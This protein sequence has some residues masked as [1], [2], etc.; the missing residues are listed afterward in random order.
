MQLKLLKPWK[1]FQAG[2]VIEVDEPTANSLKAAEVACD[3][4]AADVARI[5]EQKQLVQCAVA[6]AVKGLKP[7]SVASAEERITEY[8]NFGG[9][10]RAVRSRNVQYRQRD[11][12]PCGNNETT[13]DEGGYLVDQQFSRTLLTRMAQNGA[14]AAGLDRI[15]IGAGYNGLKF[16]ELRDY[17]RRDGQHA[18]NVYRIAEACEKTKSMPKF[19]RRALDLEKLVGL[20]CAT[21]ELLQDEPALEGMVASWFGGEFGYKLDYELMN[22]AGTT[23]CLGVMNSAALVTIKRNTANRVDANDVAR[24][25]SRMYPPSIRNAEWFVNSSVLPQLIGMTIGDQP[26]WLPP[27]GLS[28]APYGTLLGRPIRICEVSP[29]LGSKGDIGFFDMSE[30]LLIEKGGVQTATSIHVLFVTDQTMYRFVLRLNGFPKWSRTLYPN[31]GTDQV[32]PWVVLEGASGGTPTPT[33]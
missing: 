6:E 28:V 21:D 16:N 29:V 33:I 26:V 14:L 12:T 9:F 30:Y 18:V 7:T 22:G 8:K 1:A 5:E 10:L 11:C 2:S 4:S 20:Y 19:N 23:E 3:W 31:T 25:Y 15:P 32:S 24:M 13:D 27:G 17:D